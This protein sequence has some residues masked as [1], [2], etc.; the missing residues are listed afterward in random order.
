MERITA[1]ACV[2]MLYIGP[3]GPASIAITWAHSVRAGVCVCSRRDKNIS[4]LLTTLNGSLFSTAIP[5]EVAS[6]YGDY[7]RIC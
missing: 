1:I 2:T 5:D 4:T 6:G 7:L 3:R